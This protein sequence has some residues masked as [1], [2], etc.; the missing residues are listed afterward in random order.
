VKLL[1]EGAIAFEKP[2]RHRR[3]RLQ[4]LVDFQIRRREERRGALN[5]LTEEASEPGL[6]EG[7]P[8]DYATGLK[9][10]RPRRARS[11]SE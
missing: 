10:A 7:S 2:N 6:Y 1:E 3:V 9:S 4:D 8:A 5:H 11:A